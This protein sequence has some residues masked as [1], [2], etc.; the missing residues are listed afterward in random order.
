MISAGVSGLAPSVAHVQPRSGDQT[1]AQTDMS[2]IPYVHAGYRFGDFGV[3][4]SFDVPFGSGLSW[5]TD[6]RGRFEITSIELQVFEVAGVVVWRP[7]D[8]LSIAAG[9]R[10][11]RSTVGY[12]RQIDAVD[13][14]G[15]VLLAGDATGIGGQLAMMY[16]PTDR[17][18]LG[19]SWR[20]RMHLDFSGW[21]DFN[22]VPIELQQKAHDQFVTTELTL[23]DRVALGAAWRFD[24]AVASVDVTYWTWST[25]QEFGI[26]F[27][28]EQTPDVTQPRNWSDSVTLS[29]GWEQRGLVDDLALRMGLAFDS[30]PSPSSTLSPSSPDGNRLIPSVGAGYTVTNDVQLDV[31]YGRVIF[32]GAEATGNAFPGSYDA[33]ADLLSLGLTY[34]P[35]SSGN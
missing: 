33:S 34:R 23:P 11:G 26:D 18:T 12:G 9:P 22:D 17:L 31:S 29:A 32:L 20:S 8:E 16:R 10:L 2:A 30:A 35:R 25:F 15:S 21:A 1:A 3:G 27:E 6:W 4:F 28:D 7:I 19:L 13:T 14:E 5:P 24:D